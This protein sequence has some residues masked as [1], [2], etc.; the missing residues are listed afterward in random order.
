MVQPVHRSNHD[1]DATLSGVVL[2]TSCA[3]GAAAVPE[4]ACPLPQ[5]STNI[6]ETS[7]TID[8][9][10][11]VID[12]GFAKQ[13]VY[14][15]RIR[16]ESLLVSPISRVCRG[17]GSCTPCSLCS[18][19]FVRLAAQQLPSACIALCSVVHL[20]TLN[21]DSWYLC[22][23]AHTS[24]QAVQAARSLAS[25]SGYTRCALSHG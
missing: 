22:R 14:N 1:V 19:S 16:V 5:V 2:A 6:A 4:C 18:I 23:P 8:G 25:A 12:P 24:G 11:Y 13:K 15:P 9:I 10:V 3:A 7:L 21:V 17:C 20:S